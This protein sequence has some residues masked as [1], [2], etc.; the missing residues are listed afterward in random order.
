MK[1]EWTLERMNFMRTKKT[2]NELRR[3]YAVCMSEE[4]EALLRSLDLDG[5]SRAKGL[6][7]L[8]K[9][10]IE[11]NREGKFNALDVERILEKK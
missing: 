2:E 9:L 7:N 11:L 4:E 5:K 3:N 1:K 8:L 6:S 10:M